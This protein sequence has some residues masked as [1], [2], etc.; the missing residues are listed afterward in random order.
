M[1]LKESGRALNKENILIKKLSV[2]FRPGK[3]FKNTHTTDKIRRQNKSKPLYTLTGTVKRHPGGFG[4]FIPEKPEHPDIYLPK[5]QMPGL[6]NND[7]V[8]IAVIARPQNRRASPAKNRNHLQKSRNFGRRGLY[9][10]KILHLV[11]RAHEYIVGQYFPLSGGEGGLIRDDSSQ[12]GE[13]LKIRLKQKQKIKQGEW[14]QA[15]ILHYP[16]SSKGLSG[17]ITC[18]LGDFPSALEDNIR[19]VQKNN[20]PAVFPE[21]C[22]KEAK[23]SFLD[24]G[25]RKDLR[26]LPFVTIDGATAQDFDDAIYVSQSLQ[27]WTLYVAIADVSHYVT[28]NSAMDKEAFHR[29]NSLYFPGWTLPMLPEK[30]SNDLCSLKPGEDRLTFVAEIH[31]NTQ[32]E[33]QKAKFYTALIHSQ[34]RLNYGEAQEIIEN[35]VYS[36]NGRVKGGQN[37]GKQKAF[38]EPVVQN[39]RASEKLAQRLIKNRLKKHFINLEIPETEISLNALGEPTDIRQTH[40]LFSHRL[41]EELMLSANTAVAEYLQKHKV[42]SIYRI[43]DPPKTESLKFLESFAGHRGLKVRLTEPHL[44]KKISDLIQEFAGQALTEVV[45]T[46]ILRSLS[47]AV[48]SAQNSRHFG[49]NTRYYTHFTSP[50]RRY[51]DLTLHRILKAVLAQKKPVYSESELSRISAVVSSCEQ[52]SVKAERQIKDIKRARFIKKHI[53]EEMEGMI[54]SL[55][56][57]GLFVKLRLYDVEGLIPINSLPGRWEFE[58]A[59]L[60]LVSPVSGKRFKMGEQVSIQVAGADIETGQ[61]DFE[62]KKHAGKPVKQPARPIRKKKKKHKKS[63]RKGG[64]RGKKSGRKAY[65]FKKR[66]KNSNTPQNSR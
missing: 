43:H 45:Q 52:R 31:F 15:K 28:K 1:S 56:R 38:S 59:L 50:I 25:Q 39:V 44:H 8:K 65:M 30:L 5:N 49:L 35:P 53:G 46:L 55:T 40:R 18:S 13:D 9:S 27:G 2:P 10:G 6:M 17:E 63:G 29:G 33:K 41:I 12:W 37:G 24:K 26:H 54:C 14:V 21:N 60:E 57:F 22:L 51:S 42:P 62:L 4:F 3:L 20:I 58:E 11:E 23:S 32:G 36:R 48:Y 7:K 16:D 19:V 47:Q 61:I 64:R 34:A 66:K